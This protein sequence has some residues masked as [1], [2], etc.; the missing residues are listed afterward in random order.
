M[1]VAERR[2]VAFMKN[3]ITENVVCLS[4]SANGNRDVWSSKESESSSA[5]HLVIMVHE[6]MR[7]VA[8]W[9]GDQG[10]EVIVG[11]GVTGAALAHTLV[12]TFCPILKKSEVRKKRKSIS[13]CCSRSSSSVTK[14]LVQYKTHGYQG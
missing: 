8:D 2:S 9:K 12:A 1:P 7:T 11:A 6:I 10:Q 4:E 3:G 13:S 5:D 14:T